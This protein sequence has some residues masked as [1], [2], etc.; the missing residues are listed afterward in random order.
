MRKAYHAPVF[1]MPAG[2]NFV[3][4]SILGGLCILALAS[5]DELNGLS[6][7]AI[8]GFVPPPNK[9]LS[10]I[11]STPGVDFVRYEAPDPPDGGYAFSYQGKSGVDGILQFYREGSQVRFDDHVLCRNCTP[12][13]HTVDVTRRVM[14]VIEERLEREAGLTCLRRAIT[15]SRTRVKC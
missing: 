1:K 5:C 10:I 8:V 14:L 11:R 9:V 7:E 12:S 13:Q 4:R 3:M 6:R 15:Q 2:K